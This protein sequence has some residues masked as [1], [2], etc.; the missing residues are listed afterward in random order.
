MQVEMS[1]PE[2]QDVLEQAWFDAEFDAIIEFAFGAESSSPPGLPTGEGSPWRWP[3]R[4][5][6]VAGQHPCRPVRLAAQI[7][8]CQRSPP[9]R[10]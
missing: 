8:G 10:A 2:L 3:D 9:R 1:Q 7:T 4:P 6:P 5:L